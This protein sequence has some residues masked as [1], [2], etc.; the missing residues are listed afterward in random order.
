MRHL[1]HLLEYAGLLVLTK[2]AQVLPLSFVLS[3]GTAL[4]RFIFS[5]L[6]I[7]RNVV[8]ENLSY[9]FPEKKVTELYK[10]ARRNYENFG[11]MVLE[12][13]RLP[14]LSAKEIDT[15]VRFRSQEDKLLVDKVLQKGK[16]AICVTAHFGNWEYLG[17]LLAA[18]YPMIFLYQHQNNPYVDKFIMRTRIANGVESIARGSALRGIL[19]ALRQRKFVGLLADQDAGRSGI[20]VDFFGRPASTAQGPAAFVLRTGAP[21]LLGFTI[22]QQDGTHLLATEMLQCDLQ[23]DWNDE[24]KMYEITKQWTQILEKYIRLYPDHWFWMHRRWKT[25]PP[26][27]HSQQEA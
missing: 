20:F 24:Q 3:L 11:M 18:R 1:K 16:G 6:K 5:I 26:Q 15:L 4:G 22:R 23:Q 2:I 17:P 12:Y 25:R 9:A 7:R 27:D 19:K 8:F 10:I 21:M 14:K 13:L